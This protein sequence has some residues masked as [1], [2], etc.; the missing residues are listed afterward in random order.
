MNSKNQTGLGHKPVLWCVTFWEKP[1]RNWKAILHND[2][3]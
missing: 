2:V 3:K 1:H